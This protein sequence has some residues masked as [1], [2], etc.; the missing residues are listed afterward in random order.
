[1]VI[2]GVRRRASGVSKQSAKLD[3]NDEDSDGDRSQDDELCD[4]PSSS[5]SRDFNDSKLIELPE[6]LGNDR[7][8]F[9]RRREQAVADGSSK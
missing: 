9:P 3:D 1:M 8:R 4:S 2:Q 5:A 7:F 6:R